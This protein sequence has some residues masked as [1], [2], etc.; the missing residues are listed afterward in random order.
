MTARLVMLVCGALACALPAR[1][2]TSVG[3]APAAF[4]NVGAAA[5]SAGMAGATL[6]LGDG[7]AAAAWNPAALAAVDRTGFALAHAPAPAGASHDWLATGGRGAGAMRWGLQ[8]VVQRESGIEGRDPAGNPTGD[9]SVSDL[10][11]AVRVAHPLGRAIGIGVGAEWVTE[12]LAGVN[13]SGLAFE[14]GA[15]VRS[16][17]FGAAVAAR[18]VGGGIRYGGTRY[19]LPAVLAAG[20]AWDDVARGARVALDLESPTHG[21]RSVRAGGEWRWRDRLALRAGWRQM[22]ESS[23]DDALTGASFGLGVAAGPAWL[24]YA[25]TP[26][27]D[28]AAGA[29]R[30]GLSFRGASREARASDASPV[31]EPAVAA[32]VRPESPR[33]AVVTTRV[34]APAA[35]PVTRPVPVPTVP[36]TRPVPVPT[37][38]VVVPAP[39]PVPIAAEDLVV[40]PEPATASAAVVERAVTVGRT[41]LALSSRTVVPVVP[42]PVPPTVEPEPRVP[43]PTMAAAQTPVAR[44]A[45][46]PVPNRAAAVEPPPSVVTTPA[47]RPKQVAVGEGETLASLAARWSVSVAAMMM[48]NDLVN[49]HV[50][51]GQRLRL[52]PASRRSGRD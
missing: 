17:S 23:S 7:L 52:P 32:V 31:R 47:P 30:I 45:V 13:G 5:S 37:V 9:L 42:R 36:V 48:E 1:A 39:V 38:P 15:R 27:G 35:P 28:E 24:D 12:S 2:A 51:S 50:H 8:A 16:G 14:A 4:L 6:A 21:R 3:T 33:P 26:Q 44:T 22:L 19:D 10:A 41:P 20:V 18:H 29:H 43:A 11:L 49:T 25:F 34:P 40:L 46:A